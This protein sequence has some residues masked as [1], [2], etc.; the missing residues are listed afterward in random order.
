MA[1]YDGSL[2]FDTKIDTKGFTAG[3]NTIKSQANNLKNT[4]L[5]LGK[6]ILVVFGVRQLIQF[7]K[8]AIE[9]ASDL[10]EVQNVVDTAFGEMSYKMEEF[11]EKSIETFGVSRLAAKQTGSTFMAMARGMGIAIDGASD[12]AIALTGLSADMAS[13][14]NVSQDVASTA[15]K[16]VFTGETETLKQFGI[17]MTEAN[18]QAFAMSQGIKKQISAMSQ[19]EK[20]QLRYAFVMQQTALA[21]GDF[22]R[23]SDSWANQT[24]ILSE[25]WKEFLGI[26]GNGLIQVLTP[27]VKLLNTVMSY[28]ISFANA[29]TKVLSSI[30]GLGGAT[31]KVANNTSSIAI[32]SGDASAGLSNMG[33]S[34]KKAA[35]DSN[36]SLSSIDNL[37]IVAAD[38]AQNS[39]DAA[40]ALADMGGVGG[41]FDI[42]ET[43]IG[44]PDTSALEESMIKTINAIKANL[45]PLLDAFDR[46]KVAVTPFAENI[47]TGLK[48]FFDNILVPLGKW[49]I[50]ELLPAFLD[51]LGGAISVLNS[52]IEVFK[53]YALWLWEN[54]LLP[55]AQWTGGLIITVLKSLADGLYSL[56]DWIMNNQDLVANAAIMIASFFAAFKIAEFIVAVA[57]FISTLASMISSGTLLSTVLSGIGAAFSAILSPV[58]IITTILGL[59]IYSFID[60]YNNSE[61][62]RQSIA[63]LGAT[64]ME[65]LQPLAEFVGGVLSDAWNKILKPIIDFFINILLPNLIDTFK[66]LWENVLVPLGDFIGTVLQPVFQVLSDL[67][68]MLW[69]KVILPLADAVGGVLKKAWDGLYQILNK[70]VIPIINKVIEVLKFL[71]EKVINPVISVLWDTLKPAFDTVFSGI[72]DVINGLGKTLGGIIDFI[73]GVFTGDWSKAWE[74]IKNIFKG[75]WDALVGIVKVPINLIIDLINGLVGGIVKGLNLVIGALNKIKIDVPDW[76]PGIGGKTIGFNI[77]TL[78]APK[79]P[80]LATG[81][82]VPANY[83][84]FL[85]ILGD[86]KREAEVVSPLSTMKH[87]LKEAMMEMGGAGTGTI[88]LNVYLEGRQIHSEVVR[89]DKQYRNE[90]GK[91]AFAY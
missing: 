12:M 68:S 5:S 52:V 33:K 3:T 66:N 18:L 31:E 70:T 79:I 13:F 56:S 89:Q 19:A 51:A 73:T 24:R 84:E 37:N 76:I 6:T 38:I 30:F 32:S 4:L 29:A 53:P 46:L 17:V 77:S 25:Q 58:T 74:G 55:I 39:E 21:Q 69:E 91:S 40:G 34:A 10:Q 2:N 48:W 67:L 20:V 72:G 63:E 59:L 14:Y 42:G 9:I 54:F 57:P 22:A 62:F 35:K 65:A 7:G 80:K 87:A 44:G 45:Q 47:G 36:K 11:A 15:L 78:T 49:T 64:W 86:N 16:S 1:S 27:V 83:G 85:A 50:T 28:L 88:N 8:Q 26:L 61:T 23:T 81:T 82:V 60:L 75:I 90:T 71:W 41:G 43:A